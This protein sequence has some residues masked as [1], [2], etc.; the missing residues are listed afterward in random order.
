MN[1]PIS[2]QAQQLLQSLQYIS[3]SLKTVQGDVELLVESINTLNKS[4]IDLEY[5]KNDLFIEVKTA[6][7]A[8]AKTLAAI[9]NLKGGAE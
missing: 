8:I 6:R 1:A 5:F 3:L 2:Y 4:K 9:D 7:E